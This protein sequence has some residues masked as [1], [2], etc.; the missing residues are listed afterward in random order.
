VV[1]YFLEENILSRFG[2]PRKIVTDNA[3][4]FKSMAMISFCQK[5]NIILGHSMTYFPQGNGLA[6][7]LNKILI[8][9]IMKV[10]NE[11]KRSWHIHLKYALWENQIGTKKSIGISPFQMVYGTDVV[12]PINLAL[13]IM[14]LWKYEKEEPNHI[15]RRINQLIELQQNRVAV[16]ERLQKYQDDMKTLFDRKTKDIEFL[17]GDL[18]LIWDA[19]KEDSVKHDKF[20]HIWYGPFRVATSEGKNSFLL[21]NLDGKIF[22]AP[23][24]GRYLKHYMT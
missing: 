22:N 5:Y 15:T 10:L 6:E 21:E 9:I 11:N 12:L 4:A 7:S 14:K 18:V 2:C 13:P 16:D 17:P 24:N 3:L 8:N 1:I 19:R 20:D 23:V